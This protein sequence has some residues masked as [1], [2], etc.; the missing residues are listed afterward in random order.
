MQL[1]FVDKPS[2]KDKPKEKDKPSEK[3][4]KPDP[5]KNLPDFKNFFL[6]P[7]PQKLLNTEEK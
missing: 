6:E 7:P 1:G 2:E 3:E 4:D 5:K